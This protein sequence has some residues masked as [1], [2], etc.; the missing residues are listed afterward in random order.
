M[1]FQP[2]TDKDLPSA[3]CCFLQASSRTN[4][5]EGT[6]HERMPCIDDNNVL[7]VV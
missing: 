2:L 7:D 5:C 6:V 1:K 4:G 3:Y